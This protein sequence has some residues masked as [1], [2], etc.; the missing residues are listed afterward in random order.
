MVCFVVCVHALFPIF[1]LNELVQKDRTRHLVET[2]RKGLAC[3]DFVGT[4]HNR[5]W[6]NYDIHIVCAVIASTDAVKRESYGLVGI[7]RVYQ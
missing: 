6:V 4:R 7:G 5:A 1:F 3:F 2:F